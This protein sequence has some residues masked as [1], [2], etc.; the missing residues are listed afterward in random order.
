M[1][2]TNAQPMSISDDQ[3]RMYGELY[4]CH[5][6]DPKALFHNDQESQYERFELLTRCFSRETGAFS[7]HEIGC[8]LGHFG[9]L[10]RERFPQAVFS[11]SDIYEPFV[12]KCRE[13]FPHCEFFLRDITE[14]L[15]ADRYDY[16]VLCGLFNIPGNI[17]REAWQRF[18]FS[19]LS[20][21]YAMARKGIGATFLTTYYDPGRNREDLYY[22]DEKRLMDFAVRHLSRHFE[23][24]ACGPLY[25]YALRLYRPEH[26]RTLYPQ[27]AFVR[28]FKKK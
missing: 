13:H 2:I 8:A 9:D 6:D 19:M 20:A 22:Q 1:S 14:E 12:A 4:Q 27:D 24:D 26:V 28:Y 5:G 3:R 21:M 11:G 25:E 16:V 15:P 7:V 17:P 10:L 23:L 18:V